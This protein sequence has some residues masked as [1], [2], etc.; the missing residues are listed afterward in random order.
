MTTNTL[1][2]IGLPVVLAALIGGGVGYAAHGSSNHDMAMPSNSATT[3]ASGSISAVAGRASAT[4]HNAQDVSFATD[5][6]AHHQQ[7]LLM[8]QMAD[9]QASSDAVKTLAKTIEAAQ[10]P[11]INQMQSWLASWGESADS[12]SSSMSDM[13]HDMSSMSG[14]TGSMMSEADMTALSRASGA[15][16]DKM[17]LTMMTQHHNGAIG[18]AKTELAKGQYG[19]ALALAASISVSQQAQVTQMQ[20]LLKQL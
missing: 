6:V 3:S 13:N 18:M 4:S 7:A 11:E 15:D 12:A 14:G 5:M 20:Q 8:A 9:G 16:F 19:D 2:K 17:F 10:Q 1:T